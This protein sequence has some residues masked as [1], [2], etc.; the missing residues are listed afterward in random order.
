MEVR[1]RGPHAGEVARAVR[2]PG[3]AIPYIGI[4][5]S[6][7]SVMSTFMATAAHTSLPPVKSYFE[8]LTSLVFWGSG[9]GRTQKINLFL[10][11]E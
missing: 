1:R 9:S 10:H 7:G 11:I 2:E 5:W 8:P 4:G 3:R 6:S